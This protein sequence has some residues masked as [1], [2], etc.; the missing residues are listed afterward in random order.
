MSKLKA[1]LA[2][3]RSSTSATVARCLFSSFNGRLLSGKNIARGNELLLRPKLFCWFD[4]FSVRPCSAH[5]GLKKTWQKPKGHETDI[6]VYNSLTRTKEPFVLADSRTASWYSCGPTV[7]DHAHLGHAS[8]YVRFDIVRRILTKVFGIDVVMVMVITDIDD[9]IIRRA[10]ELNVSP[11]VLARIYEEDFKQDM[12]S[13]KVLPPTVYMRVTDNIP[14]I[15]D[16]IDKIIYNGNAYATS[17]GNVYFDIQ[18][19]GSR[20]GKLIGVSADFVGDD[21][22][23][24]RDFALWKASKPQEPFWESPWGRGRPGWH[25]ECSTVASSVFGNKLD[26]H[27]GGIDLAFP[28]HE[29]EIAQ[30]EAYHQCEQWGNY[31]LHSGHLHLKGSEEKMSK[32]LKNYITIQDFLETFTANQFRMFCLLS[33]YRSAVDYSEASMS[34]AKAHLQSI[35][36]FINNASAYMRGQ[37]MCP[38]VDEILLWERLSTTKINVQTALADDFDTPRAIDS[39]MNLVHHGNRQLQVVPKGAGYTRSP[40]VFGSIISYIDQFLDTVGISL[41]ENQVTTE[42][43][44]LAALHGIVD[45]LVDFRQKVR[46]YAL[47]VDEPQLKDKKRRLMNERQPLLQACDSL[48][49]DLTAIGIDIKVSE[50]IQRTMLQFNNLFNLPICCHQLD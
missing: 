29:N 25:I 7:Y 15:V 27:S 5:A 23:D 50:S 24:A 35:S 28:H 46:N 3:L 2:H 8:S 32:S 36:S 26:I 43:Q 19:I 14:K 17:T 40:V 12:T 22:K 16:Y 30:C 34:E 44:S 1:P 20:Y 13:L 37:L 33:K 18:S 45:Q 49:L 4:H 21:K 6:K 47:A 41:R 10:N 9:K 42:G 39:I 31:F 11:A 38:E 48:R